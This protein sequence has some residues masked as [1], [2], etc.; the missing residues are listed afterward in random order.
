M[1]I[2]KMQIKFKIWLA[3]N[4][5]TNLMGDGRWML[6]KKVEELGSLMAASQ[7]MGISY[8]KAWGDLK[9]FQ[10]A[11]GIKL[12]KTQR[13]GKIGGQTALTDAGKTLL[14]E[15]E[16]MHEKIHQCILK[17]FNNFETKVLHLLKM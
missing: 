9:K 14:T 10:E 12:L 4:D 11:M 8:R 2:A 17:E 5:G 13:G 16:I 3:A 6:L 7:A 15:Y 1:N